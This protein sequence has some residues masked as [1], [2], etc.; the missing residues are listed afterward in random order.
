MPREVE[1]FSELGHARGHSPDLP[2]CRNDD[3]PL[4]WGHVGVWTMKKMIIWLALVLLTC[5]LV[6]GWALGEPASIMTLKDWRAR[7]PMARL[8]MVLGALALAGML[9]FACPRPMSAGEIETALKTK[10]LNED[11][12]E[13]W[14]ASMIQ[15]MEAQGCAVPAGETPRETLQ[16]E[17]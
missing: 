7:I 16:G 4:P 10:A 2:G 12:H 17:T 13:P 14:V 11:E 3:G 5:S 15:L 8:Y 6:H 9:D 1:W